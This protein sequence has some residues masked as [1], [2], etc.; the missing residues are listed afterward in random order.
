MDSKKMPNRREQKI[1]MVKR[2][3]DK[4]S[5]G[6]QKCP[7]LPAHYFALGGNIERDKREDGCMIHRNIYGETTILRKN[8]LL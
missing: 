7:D 2:N 6:N 8:L 5:K 3:T 4:E 1:I